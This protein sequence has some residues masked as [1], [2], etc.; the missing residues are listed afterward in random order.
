[1]FGR[2]GEA[3]RTTRSDVGR[4]SGEGVEGGGSEVGKGRAGGRLN[5]ATV[6]IATHDPIVSSANGIEVGNG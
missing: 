2:D 5:L 6:V 3:N 1:M 4:G